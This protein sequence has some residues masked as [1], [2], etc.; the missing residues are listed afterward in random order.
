MARLN[1]PPIAPPP[2]VESND[3]ELVAGAHARRF[4]NRV[5][6]LMGSCSQTKILEAESRAC[7]V[8]VAVW[9]ALFRYED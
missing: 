8:C 6:L 3:A 9:G 7:K 2:P 4:H 1:E 5:L